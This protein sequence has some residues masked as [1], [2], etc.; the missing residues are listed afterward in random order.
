MA[1]KPSLVTPEIGFQRTASL[2][3][4]RR[5]SS[6]LFCLPP[7]LPPAAL[8]AGNTPTTT[9]VRAPAFA[10]MKR[11]VRRSTK[12]AGGAANPR[13]EVASMGTNNSRAELCSR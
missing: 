2:F 7:P 5:A 9:A 4:P 11:A 8:P 6:Q 1:E 3:A 13:R 12:L 10:A